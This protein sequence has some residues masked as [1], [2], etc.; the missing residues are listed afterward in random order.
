[1][2]NIHLKMKVS[3]IFLSLLVMFNCEL[4][5]IDI[6]EWQGN[7]DW[8]AVRSAKYFAIIRAGYGTSGVDKYYQQNYDNAKA[9]GVKV[10][11]YL[12]S[13]AGSGDEADAEA[14]HFVDLLRGKQFEWPVYY[15]IEE[16]S[17]F[18][19][20]IQNEI[21]RRFCSILEANRYYC[22][23]YASA[24]R[25][26]SNFDQD[27]K[28]KYTIWVAHWGVPQP[29]YT[30]TYHVWQ[31]TSD[32]SCPGIGGRVDQDVGYLDFEPVMKKAHLNGY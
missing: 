14:N 13:Y 18:D 15:D 24:S 25:L 23:I 31:S 8:G 6:S 5:G 32:G 30:G 17:I 11:A 4:Y 12:Y 3:L 29:S 21:A 28:D 27:V 20:G 9:A 26:N 2:H 7:I 19:R 22:G 1:M 16:G 10:G